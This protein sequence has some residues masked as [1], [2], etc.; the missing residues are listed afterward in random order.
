[1]TPVER[2]CSPMRRPLWYPLAALMAGILIGDRIALPPAVLLAGIPPVLALL[3]LS[4]RRRWNAAGLILL[5]LLMLT[6]GMLNIQ[7]QPFLAL[8]DRHV[9]RLADQGKMTLEGVVL[10]SEQA[11]PEKNTLIVR[12]R[13][14]LQNHAPA[15]VT[16]KI[17]VAIPPELSFQY[18]DF[19]R[20]HTK[21]KKIQGFHNPGGFDYERSQNRSGLYVSGFVSDRSGIVLI[22]PDAASGIRLK[23]ECFRL[24][25]KRLM[26]AH[27]PS[28]QREILQA[29]TIGN[30]KAIP[31][32]VRD[33]FA[34]TGTSH[35]LSIS[36]LHVGIV[37][38]SAFFLLLL[39]FKSSEYCM[40]KFNI[41]K[42]ATAAAMVPVLIYALVAGMGT[43][44][45]RAT[46]MTLAFLAAMLIG[47]PK[48]LYNIL[49]GAAL[50]ILIASPEALYEI[51]FQLSFSAV[52]AI[53]YTVDK[54][55]KRQ[56]PLPSSTPR[57]I[58]AGIGR[59][60]LF[61]LVSAA[62]ALGTLPIIAFYFNRVSAVTLIANLV[63]VPLL[64]I[65]ALI[66]AM[67]FILTSVFSE[68]LAGFFISIASFFTGIAVRI[69]EELA[70][71]PWSSFSFVKPN[72]VEIALF[73]ALMYFLI[74]A[75]SPES[76]K[77]L[78]KVSSRRPFWIKTGLLICTALILADAAFLVLKDRYSSHLN[79]TAIDVGQGSSTLVQMPGGM[80]ML[81]DGGG[82]HDSSFD[83]GRAVI[84][85]FLYAKRIRK[86][87]IAVLTHPHP[88]HLQGLIYILNNFDV[89]E[90]WHT[91]LTA[92]DDLYS[93]WEKTIAE[94]GI[95]VRILSAQSP[96]ANLS[97]VNFRFLWPPRPPD[98]VS[99]DPSYEETN[100]ASLVMKITY[101]TRR[102]LVTGDIS[103]S[104][105][106]FLTASGKDLQSDVLFVP[107]HGSFTS[108]SPDFIR[109]V[110]CRYAVI[111][112]GK[113]NVFRH[114]HPAVLER[115]RSAGAAV[116]RTDRDGAV[117]I[118]S[119][120]Q[121]LRATP[122]I[123]KPKPDRMKRRAPNISLPTTG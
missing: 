41:I 113:N 12:C 98:P 1:M 27:A 68:A 114:P 86:V 70:L 37:A 42:A 77:D 96:P 60:Y 95:P 87:D 8:Q 108:S 10:S 16:G 3:L 115:Y 72:A 11:L 118:D 84:A 6:A 39:A 31:Q 61:F 24:Y 36:G 104:I 38:A 54:L 53:L 111:S 116:F 107:H 50:I 91:G 117:A 62:A 88:D 82:F 4:V 23:L 78:Q 75:L 112:A 80:N 22:R 47:R 73:Y 121:S 19:I 18:G 59:L 63:A 81:I 89:R 97:G 40:L 48:D 44:V 58:S 13:R 57:W 30:Q 17:R 55:G 94:Q 100:D 2:S 32:D 69:I 65:L 123:K 15:P 14:V 110:S 103:A 33:H 49:A 67:I 85:P 26:E 93:L 45:L 29:M 122:W 101:G 71:L 64:G 76:P 28:P 56:A 52:F 109:A 46:L 7:R 90:V 120:G 106:A 92:D 74:A 99:K 83:M 20:F 34:Q 102:F 25:L 5:L 43:P 66:P 119:D 9:L 105:E 79:I 35:I 21:I 51:S